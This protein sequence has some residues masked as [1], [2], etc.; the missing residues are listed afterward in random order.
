MQ[1]VVK[2]ESSMGRLKI[3]I[4]LGLL[5]SLTFPVALPG[6]SL[7]SSFRIII[8]N[9]SPYYVPAVAIVSSGTP[10]RWDNPTP[11]HHTITHEDCFSGGRCLF[12]SGSVP[13][14]ESYTL[15]SL[16]PGR[17]PYRCRLHPIMTGVLTIV[18]DAV[19]PSKT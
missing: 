19:P 15:L 9:E 3:G 14:D 12:D 2:G 7:P 13:P 8:G 18:G 11:T 5:G 10:I 1:E 16:P 6:F 4:L 17:H